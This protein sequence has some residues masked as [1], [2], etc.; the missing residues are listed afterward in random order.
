[1]HITV[2]AVG[3]VRGGPEMALAQDYLTRA[4]AAGRG[5][6][7]KGARL[8][9]VEG[10]RMG[11]RASEAEAIERASP[12]EARTVLLDERGEGWTS[13]DLAQRL[14]AWRDS[15][16]RDAAFW[17][18][19]ADGAGAELSAKADFQLA[20]GRQTWPHRMVRAM[21]CEQIYRALM[22]LSGNPYH[23]D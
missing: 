17:I 3:R 21:I 11:E 22:I 1:L 15:G 16:L 9:E 19:G 10:R 14:G 18:G 5:L 23:R 8:V 4:S 20:F 7:F 13:R 6:G 12:A 2:I